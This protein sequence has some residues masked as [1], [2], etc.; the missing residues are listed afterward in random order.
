[1]PKARTIQTPGVAPAAAEAPQ[2]ASAAVEGAP[3]RDDDLAEYDSDDLPAAAVPSAEELQQALAKS[4]ADNA[5][6]ARRLDALEGR[7]QPGGKAKAEPLPTQE[8]AKAMAQKE[9]ANGKRP[10]AI[11]TAEGYYCHPEMA[12]VKTQGAKEEG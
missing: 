3:F 2:E 7:M 1:M 9:I 12:R 10:R 11:L 4:L 5:K 8:E 6:L